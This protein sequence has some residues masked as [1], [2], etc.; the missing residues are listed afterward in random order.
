M[1][2]NLIAI[3]I[4]REQVEACMR[5]MSDQRLKTALQTCNAVFSRLTKDDEKYLKY[6]L[7]MSIIETEIERRSLKSFY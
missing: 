2:N 3:E 5:T 4:E 6:E 1:R 7:H